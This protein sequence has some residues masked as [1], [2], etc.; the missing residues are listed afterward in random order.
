MLQLCANEDVGS[1]FVFVAVCYTGICG[2][3]YDILKRKNDKCIVINTLLWRHNG[4]DGVSNR[5]PHN[6]LLNRS[7]R[8]RSKKT[9]VSGL[10]SGISSV[11]GEF[12]AQ[13]A[14][15]AE[16][17]AF[18]DVIVIVRIICFSLHRSNAY[19]R[20]KA[21]SFRIKLCTFKNNDLNWSPACIL[22][23]QKI[24]Y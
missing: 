10:Y 2:E 13:T 15:N 11:I 20:L 5:Q 9:R 23:L 12:P 14:S 4:R 17:A 3:C 8:R 22:L 18:D 16:N 1:V 19:M 21:G 7:V 24:C 6:C